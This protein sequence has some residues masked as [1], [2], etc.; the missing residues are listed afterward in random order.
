M[1][2]IAARLE[3]L[4]V[5]NSAVLPSADPIP[6]AVQFVQALYRGGYGRVLI[7]TTAPAE[8][9]NDTI[10]EW[11]R[12]YQIPMTDLVRLEPGDGV[13]EEDLILSAA[14]GRATVLG[15]YVVAY[16]YEV[17]Y[18]AA[19]GVPTVTFAHADPV[20]DYRPERGVTWAK[21]GLGEEDG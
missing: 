14:G 6:A 19:H 7:V 11:M 20:I 2:S 5:E 16:P 10:V 9:T 1:K 4:L 13:P 17:G 3:G 12:W 21:F 15:L 8:V 18:M